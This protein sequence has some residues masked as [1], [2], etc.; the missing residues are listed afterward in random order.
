MSVGSVPSATPI[1]NGAAVNVRFLLGPQ[2]TGPGGRFCVVPEVLPDA[3]GE[4]FCYIGGSGGGV[5]YAPGDFDNDHVADVPLYN[6]STGA[7][8]LLKSGASFNSSSTLNW[9]GAGFLPVPGDYDGDNRLDAGL[10][11]ESTGKWT[12]LKSSTNF[13]TPFTLNWGGPGYMAVP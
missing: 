3:I 10:Y 7:W 13:T 4:P 6:R 12:V 5:T 2:A 9:G 11:Q 1:P 8:T